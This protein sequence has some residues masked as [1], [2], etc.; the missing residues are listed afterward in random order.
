MQTVGRELKGTNPISDQETRRDSL[1]KDSP[2]EAAAEEAR[3]IVRAAEEDGITLRLIGGLAIRFH[4]HGSHVS[5]LREYHDID[6]LGLAK[7][8]EA[9]ATAFRR[10]GYSPNFKYNLL[11]GGSRLQFVDDATGKNVDVFLDRFAMD[12][13]LDFRQRLRLDDLTIPVTDLLLTKLQMVKLETKDV[14]DIVAILEDHEL[15]HKDDR[16]TLNTEYMAKLCGSDWGLYKTVSDNLHKMDEVIGQTVPSAEERRALAAK[17]D[18]IRVSLEK[19]KKGAR[20]K[21]RSLIGE[22]KRWYEP[23]EVGEGETY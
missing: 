17:L 10:L 19:S 8:S 14:K 15:G 22:K 2:H 20:W 4:C 11:Y 6:A 5:H 3:R 21:I 18:T 9:M 23:V 16:E 7:E 13:T 1:D 12:H